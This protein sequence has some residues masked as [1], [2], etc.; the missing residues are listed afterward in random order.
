MK[1]YKFQINILLYLNIYIIVVNSIKWTQT[2]IKTRC[3]RAVGKAASNI[4]DTHNTVRFGRVNLFAT[5][6]AMACQFYFRPPLEFYFSSRSRHTRRAT[7]RLSLPPARKYPDGLYIPLD[8]GRPAAA[9]FRRGKEATERKYSPK[10]ITD[11]SRRSEFV[12]DGRNLRTA[13]IA[14]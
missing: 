12:V 13:Q 8:K 4:T 7:D 11:S 6:R 9:P 2:N 3:V 5:I 10:K 14:R 1:I